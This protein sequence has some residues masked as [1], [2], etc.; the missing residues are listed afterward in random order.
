MQ[1]RCEVQRA[2]RGTRGGAAPSTGQ[3]QAKDLHRPIAQRKLRKLAQTPGESRPLALAGVLVASLMM[4]PHTFFE[5]SLTLCI[6][7]WDMSER[8][9]TDVKLANSHVSTVSESIVWHG[10]SVRA[11]SLQS[12]CNRA[13]VAKVRHSQLDCQSPLSNSGRL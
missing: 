12:R 13:A 8:L 10:D 3:V 2:D 6:V 9:E 7:E 11:S 5:C 1:R 4:K